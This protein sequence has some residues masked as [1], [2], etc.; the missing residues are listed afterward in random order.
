MKIVLVIVA[1]LSLAGCDGYL[2]THDTPDTPKAPD[3]CVRLYH[4]TEGDDQTTDEYRG[5]YCKQDSQ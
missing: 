5:V 1:V 4:H 2:K 3:G